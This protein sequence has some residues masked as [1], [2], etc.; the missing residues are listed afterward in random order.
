VIDYLWGQPAADAMMALLSA[1][2]DRAKAVNW[3]QIGSVAGPTMALPSVALRSTNLRV[4]GSG[5]GSVSVRAIVGELPRLV[6]ELVAGRISV[7]ALRVPL[8]DVEIAWNAPVP[9]GRR[10]VL[11]P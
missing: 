3:I 5:Q 8:A 6:D 2:E 4:L 11:V 9:A 10:V 1:R 7:D